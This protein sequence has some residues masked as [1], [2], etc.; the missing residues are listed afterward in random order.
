MTAPPPPLLFLLLVAFLSRKAAT[1]CL[2]YSFQRTLDVDGA[3]AG[4]L[5]T[6]R[7]G[8]LLTVMSERFWLTTRA[9]ACQI[10]RPTWQLNSAGGR[11]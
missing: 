11:I 1:T 4:L 10:A 6:P 2:T 8:G 9:R 3:L 7:V 5:P